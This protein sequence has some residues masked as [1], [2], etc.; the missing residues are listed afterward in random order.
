MSYIDEL[1]AAAVKANEASDRATQASQTMFDIANGGDT[2]VVLTA[3]GEVL[4][5]AHA[6]RQVREDVASGAVAPISETTTIAELG[7]Q[8]IAFQTLN[9]NGIA[10]Y[11]QNGEGLTNR[12]FNFEVTA[13]NAVN[14]GDEFPAGTV[15]VGVA[16]EI[17]GEVKTAVEQTQANATLAQDWAEK[18]TG[19]INGEGFSA[20]YHANR[21]ATSEQTSIDR[22]NAAAAARD[23]ANASA[24]ASAE[25]A[26]ESAAS[27]SASQS[28][29]LASEAARDASQQAASDA[30]ASLNTLDNEVQQAQDAATSA[31]TSKN[32]A[33]AS[34][35][36]ALTSEGNASD[37]ATLASTKADESSASAAAS[38][39]SANN[40]S[41]FAN[42]AS[43]SA[44]AASA[45]E[46]ASKASEDAA[47]ASE[48][49]AATSETNS[50]ASEAAAGIS[51]A[52]AEAALVEFKGTYYGT[53]TEDPTLDPNGNAPTLGDKYF[54][55][56]NNV[57]MI[58]KSGGWTSNDLETHVA[59]VDPHTQYTRKDANLS[60]VDPV[61]ARQN[62]DV[63]QSSEVDVQTIVRKTSDNG[64]AVLP[65]GTTLQRPTGSGPFLRYNT[66]QETWEGSADGI[67]WGSIGGGATGSGGN[68]VFV[69]NDQIVTADY[70][71][72]GTKNAM[73]TGPVTI[74]DGV[75]VTISDGARWVII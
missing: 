26:S 54:N 7:Q 31:N 19:E 53:L 8:S 28:S 16:Q 36:A 20:K 29:R 13:S 39:A 58:Y 66:E 45:S 24:T 37:S 4:T 68:A 41:G 30:L 69:E 42:N 47:A 18:T 71:I 5:V 63:V 11:I 40:A 2:E 33:S 57:E 55:S 56:T 14:L 73:T 59:E 3:N 49:A 60:D 72:P 43:T 25:S 48:S 46:I 38:L 15:I 51:E 23:A 6:I 44:D 35:A 67:T 62:L 17:G 52:N 9:T 34:A 10:I 21:A 27:A 70:T 32:A 74:A 65:G 61:L 22:A 64:A 75:T 12:Y 50:A 1:N